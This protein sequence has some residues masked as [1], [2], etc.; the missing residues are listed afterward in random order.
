[1]AVISNR[2]TQGT[3]IG[4]GLTGVQ[5]VRFVD[6]DRVYIKSPD[7]LTGV[8]IPT[9]KSNGTTPAGYTD[10]GIIDGKLKITYDKKSKD[11]LTGIDNYFRSEYVSEKT[12]MFEFN[13]SQFD[14]VVLA[15]ISGLSASMIT[16]STTYVFNVGQED[17]VQ[18]ALILVSQNKL[19]GKE[20]QY[21]NPGAYLN[22]GFADSGDAVI[23]KC[24]AKLPFFTAVGQSSE[25]LMG[26][27]LNA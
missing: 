24:T 18:K 2:N 5:V 13:L 10:L 15:S 22:F 7:A 20:L 23:L 11:V 3:P 27:V 9:T 12:C 21:Y 14:D 4:P 17:I 19:D 8:V 25:Q 1:M 6:A 16:S 26:L